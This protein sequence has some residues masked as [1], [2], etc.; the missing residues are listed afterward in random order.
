MSKYVLIKTQRPQLCYCPDGLLV[1]LLRVYQA[2]RPGLNPACL[3]FFLNFFHC[4]QMLRKFVYV[5]LTIL[6]VFKD[7][8]VDIKA[9]VKM[10]VCQAPV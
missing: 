4:K 8:K 5:F 7:T 6:I 1:K 9:G 2:K 3:I 10:T